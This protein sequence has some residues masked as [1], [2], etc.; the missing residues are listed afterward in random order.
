MSDGTMPHGAARKRADRWLNRILP[1][2][3]LGRLTAVMAAGVLLTQLVGNVIWAAQRRAEAEV[4][5]GADA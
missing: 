3:L 4:E 5:V 1:Q 2:S